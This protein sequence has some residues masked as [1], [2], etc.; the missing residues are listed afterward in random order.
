MKFYLT[1]LTFGAAL[2]S[3]KRHKT[4]P[5]AEPSGVRPPDEYHAST[6]MDYSQVVTKVQD[7]DSCELHINQRIGLIA[8]DSQ[9]YYF[10]ISEGLSG[11]I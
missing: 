3:A 10:Q 5:A 11:D 7:K 1:L 9:Y 6:F 4:K 8:C 2:V